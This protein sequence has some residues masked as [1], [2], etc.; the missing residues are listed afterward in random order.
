MRE[1]YRPRRLLRRPGAPKRLLPRARTAHLWR[2]ACA[3][4]M[5][6][7]MVLSLLPGTAYA[8]DSYSVQFVNYDLT[9]LDGSYTFENVPEGA[10]LYTADQL[11][12]EFN[13]TVTEQE[14]HSWYLYYPGGGETGAY[15]PV[16]IADPP[17]RDGY[18]FRDW[19]VRNAASGNIYTVTGD[20]TYVARYLSESRYVISLYYQYDNESHTVAA[21][22]T[23]VPFGWGEDVSIVL[24]T[25]EALAGLSPTIRPA[26]EGKEAE[27]AAEELTAMIQN[28]AFTGEVGEVLLQRC[29]AAGFVAWD[30]SAKDYQKDE[31]GNVQVGIPVTYQ[32][33]G[34]VEFTVEYLLQNADGSGYTSGGTKK[35]SVVGTTRVSLND[36]EGM[37]PQY[38]GFTLTAASAED[39]EDYTVN[40]GGDT[41]IQLRYDRDTYH[42]LYQ[43]NGGAVREPLALRYGQDIPA[44]ALTAPTRTG[45]N[46]TT[47]TWLD[48]EG[49]TITEPDAMPDHDLTLVANWTAVEDGAGVTLVY[50]LENANDDGYTVSGQRTI[51]VTADKTIGYGAGGTASTVDVDISPYLTPEAME[52]AGIGDGEYFTFTYADAST[53]FA[54]GVN[55][56]PKTVA[57]DGSTVINLG[58]ERKEY[59]LMFHLGQVS[60]RTKYDYE[61]G[62]WQ[63]YDR[64][65]FDYQVST[66]GNSSTTTAEDWQSG[67]TW[68]TAYSYDGG[69]AP[70][71]DPAPK[72]PIEG[73][74]TGISLQVG[75]GQ[76]Y[77]IT[78]SS[79]GDLCYTITAKYGAYISDQWPLA[80]ECVDSDGT[81]FSLYTWG[82]H[83]RSPYYQSHPDNRNIIGTYPTMSA[84]LIIDPNSPEMVHHLTG[85]WQETEN[86]E[87]RT[88]HFM[89]EA[90][91]GMGQTGSH[92]VSGSP[93]LNQ[94]EGGYE[95]VQ[96]L[97]FYEFDREVV[98]TTAGADRQNA[99]SFGNLTYQYGCYVGTEIYFYY[100]YNDYTITYNENNGKDPNVVTFHYLE[101]MTLAQELEAAGHDHDYVPA[102][103]VSQYGNEYTFGGWYSDAEFSF[104]VDWSAA[105]PATNIH[106]YAKWI[107][108]TFTLTLV[109]PEGELYPETLE[110]FAE[111]GYEY[112]SDETTDPETGL[113]TT[114]YVVTGIPGG[115]Q[116]SQIVSERRGAQSSLS[117]A[118]DYWGYEV[119]GTEQPYLFDESQYITSD[120]TL[121]ARW[122]TEYTG[123]YTVRYLAAEDPGNDLGTVTVDGVTWYRL[124][125][126]KVVTGVAVGSSVTEEAI[127][128]Q[129]WLSRQGQI[130]WVVD[131][132]EDGQSATCFDFLYDRISVAD[133]TYT[134]H[135][136]LDAGEDYGR[137]APPEG[138]VR[139]AEDKPVTV[140]QASLSKSTAV[141]E[142][143]PVIGGYSPRDGWSA[144][145]ALSVADE[146]NHLYFYYVPNTY[147]V[148][149]TVVYHIPGGSD[150]TFAGLSAALGRVVTAAELTGD[151]RAWLTEEQ[152]VQVDGALVGREL[153]E[154]LTGPW[155]IVSQ[156]E[157]VYHVHLKHA[158]YVLTYHLEGSEDYPAQWTQPDSFLTAGEGTLFQTVTYPDGATVPTTQPTRLGHTFLGWS[159]TSGGT[160]ID[161]QNHIWFQEYGMT[162][163][164]VLYAV[165]QA[166]PVVSYDLRVDGA[167]WNETGPG[168]YEDGDSGLWLAYV[169]SGDTAPPPADPSLVTVEDVAYA[170]VGWT[171]TDPESD[172]WDQFVGA[173]GRV[174]LDT[175]D[176]RFRYTFTDP[177]TGPLTLYAVWDPDVTGVALKKVNGGG[178]LLAGA[179]FTLERIQ[180]SVSAEDGGYT[181]TLPPRNEDGS[182]P[183]DASFPA[184]SVTTDGNGGGAFENL[185]AGYYLLTETAA[186]E[187]YLDLEGAAVLHLPYGE[188]VPEVVA[189]HSPAHQVAGK[190]SGG[191]LTVT[192]TNTAQYDV[193]II[194]PKNLVLTY[195]PPDLIW[196]PETLAYEGLGE[197]EGSWAVTAADGKAIS[198]TNRSPASPV[199]V[200]VQLTY[201]EGYTALLPIS[202]LSAATGE[203]GT[204]LE[205]FDEERTEDALTLLGSLSADE[206]AV[207]SLTV[208]GAWPGGP[209]ALP[210]AGPAGTITISVTHPTRLN[211]ARAGSRFNNKEI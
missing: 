88:H 41:V 204:S 209:A 25:G 53:E 137:T 149:F 98:R 108:P 190:A 147:E 27:T 96:G 73:A 78:N 59:T 97:T 51:Y 179:S 182:W 122:K 135:Y 49:Q 176:D 119:N 158:D 142:N 84:E 152:A 5:C 101:N 184:R 111:R 21:E 4:V 186:P 100:T 169:N 8:A 189:E 205:G 37:V 107:A 173:D 18:V 192:V 163:D 12:S 67:Y 93:V 56:G 208:T 160:P 195:T 150:L 82:T 171:A 202:S 66:E 170:F 16:A 52:V 58:Y 156:R 86:P 9:A 116:A 193:E 132:P 31:N 65:W 79:S 167:R 200:S 68:S 89:F 15:G 174:D 165:W 136:V 11:E 39:A 26:L 198:V 62:D 139:L 124:A 131:Q 175:F 36:M 43:M 168:F 10:A 106:L 91:P 118:F 194:S 61:F 74:Y 206:T 197:T 138:I 29:L 196:N 115:I 81:G 54:Q 201:G 75:G 177:V 38:E 47:W 134:V 203:G 102:P 45:Y 50:W 83:A 64:H 90:V 109:V 128:V 103:Y 87:T 144:T 166:Q 99:P 130:T 6:A 113:T 199:Q 13:V 44:T 162:E 92:V 211:T 28:G 105:N 172:D 129:G 19:A 85:Y 191:D 40:V 180:A 133:V 123:Q 95:A 72:P 35:G 153:D 14:G 76:T 20:T 110:Q 178:E 63:I 70:R 207:F 42:I 2:R 46:F 164:H 117:L 22:T 17:A 94:G 187:G 55:G 125:A 154:T 183:L 57:G 23:T 34:T 120:L 210:P 114:T 71:G 104:P 3:L 80:S 1:K 140:D 24:P 148:T 143:A 69:R 185:P 60:E 77:Y 121:T 151:Y 161:M 181:F 32:V 126:D 127:S 146:Q 7:A 157:N 188:G 159:V 141:S 30:E 33:T 145:F 112:T 48:G 155:M